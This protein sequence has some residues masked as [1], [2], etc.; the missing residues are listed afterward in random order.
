MNETPK[1]E[2][3]GEAKGEITVHEM[4]KKGGA[5]TKELYGHEHYVKIGHMGGLIGGKV[6]KNRPPGYYEGIGKLG[7]A[8]MRELIE[9]G[10]AK[11]QAEKAAG[12]PGQE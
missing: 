9:R 8:K 7:G 4:G 10:K 12:K 5:R 3:K 6:P 2:T 11:E 1:S